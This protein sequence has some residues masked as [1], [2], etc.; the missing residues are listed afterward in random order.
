M[1]VTSRLVRSSNW[2][3][4]RSKPAASSTRASNET[5]ER[6]QH[7]ARHRLSGATRNQAVARQR[8]WTRNDVSA[9]GIILTLVLLGTIASA[10]SSCPVFWLLIGPGPVVVGFTVSAFFRHGFRRN[11]AFRRMRDPNSHH[12]GQSDRLLNPPGV[13]RNKQGDTRIVPGF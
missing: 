13:Q 9:F 3:M 5:F 8:G 12:T 10:Q 11:R 1:T 6:L 2:H 4:A 7:L